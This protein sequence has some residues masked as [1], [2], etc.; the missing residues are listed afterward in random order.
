M[1]NDSEMEIELSEQSGATL[2]KYS[3]KI[4]GYRFCARIKILGNA[5]GVLCAIFQRCRLGSHS[6]YFPERLRKWFLSVEDVLIEKD[7]VAKER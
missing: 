3:D 4:Q 5:R 7:V 2:Y 1:I 6:R